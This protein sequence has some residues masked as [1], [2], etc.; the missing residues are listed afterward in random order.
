MQQRQIILLSSILLT[1]ILALAACGGNEK[2]TATLTGPQQASLIYSYPVAG[3]REVPLQA[4]L[5]LRFSEPLTGADPASRI[6]LRDAAGA[7]VAFSA[8]SVDDGRGL[9]LTPAAA[10]APFSRYQLDADSLATASGTVALPDTLSFV[11]RAAQRGPAALVSQGAF[12]VTRMIPDG[13][14]LP[15]MDFSTL[16][17]Q[18]S[19]PL[20]QKSLN[21]GENLRLLDASGA[22]VAARVSVQGAYLS[23]D[24]VDDLTPGVQY[25][26]TLGDNLASSLGETLAVGDFASRTLIPQDSQPRATMVQEVVDSNQGS[27][28]SILTGAAVNAV[29]VKALLL[30][31]ETLTQQTGNVHAELAFIPNYPEVTPLRIAR[32]SLLLGSSV[33]VNIAG[34]VP[35]G[36]DSGEIR[37]SFISDASGYLLPNPYSRAEE[38]PRHVRLYLD[39]AMTAGTEQANAELSQDLLHVEL[40]GTAL[41]QNGVMVIDAVGVVEPRIMG[42]DDAVGLL[43][44]HM[45]AYADQNAAPQPAADTDAPFVHSWMPGEQ[46]QGKQRPGDPILVHFNEPLDRQSLNQPGA[47]TLFADGVPVTTDWRLDGATL[48]VEPNGGLKFGVNYALQLSTDLTDLAGNALT[49]RTLNF[50]LPAY[51]TEMGLG[52][53]R[54][55]FV[56]VTSPGYP[57]ATVDRPLTDLAMRNSTHQGRCLGGM[58]EAT[59]VDVD[60]DEAANPFEKGLDDLLPISVHPASRPITVSFSR[61]MIPES[62]KL[63]TSCGS[64][65]PGSFRVEHINS[66]GE[67]APVPGILTVESREIQFTPATPWQNGELYRY[68]LGSQEGDY[69]LLPSAGRP[70]CDGTDAIC[71]QVGLDPTLG[72]PSLAPL[73]P[74]PLQTALINMPNATAGGPDMEIYFRGGPDLKSLFNPLKNLPAI[75]VNANLL[76][77]KEEAE[78]APD[79]QTGAFL[80]NTTYLRPQEGSPAKIACGSSETC[81]DEFGVLAITAALNTEIVGPVGK[82][83]QV[84]LYPT[85]IAT[86]GFTV[87]IIGIRPPAGPQILRM[88]YQRQDV[89]DENSPRTE[90]IDGFI[91]YTEDGPVVETN[92]DVYMDAPSL[93]IKQPNNPDDLSQG[94]TTFR[95]SQYSLPVT[96]KLR[97][98]LT[99]LEDGR[100]QIVQRNIEAIPVEVGLMLGNFVINSIDL[101]I[102][103][104]GIYLNYVSRPMKD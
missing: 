83:V 52:Q 72:L 23:L 22:L 96:L 103:I 5:V 51:E 56:L 21:Y 102:P 45:K 19:Q 29:P 41:V 28:L 75:D 20:D 50:A 38:A 68:V 99:F 26:L 32:S 89:N 6:K 82:A 47:W 87:D 85:I 31:D 76:D 17:L 53:F 66:R 80:E 67:C 48:V 42:Q 97:G 36:F 3:Q 10:L 77:F 1:S 73:P 60:G 4:P 98:A 65:A 44:F 59:I 93:A 79:L 27:L 100:M 101:E 34:V 81:A 86:S 37:V 15:L 74:L 70:R 90:L 8:V 7:E 91:R 94:Y 11:T 40:V 71:A 104:D 13:A 57:C 30:G 43:S 33:D 16:R 88:R 12:A 25:Q 62:I 64:S 39:L 84:K 24:P 46:H 54:A 35:A 2:Q 78:Q 9:L 14:E 58:T 63:A 18:F 69:E 61:D 49:A 92:V 55:P 95:H